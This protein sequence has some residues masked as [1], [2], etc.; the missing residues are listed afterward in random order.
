[1]TTAKKASNKKATTVKAAN[2]NVLTVQ[3]LHQA[4]MN[5]NQLYVDR[6]KAKGKAPD[7][8]KAGFHESIN[9]S[10]N[11]LKGLT[12]VHLQDIASMG[13][14]ETVLNCLSDASNIK[15][16]KR[17]VQALMFALT[18][19]G[20]YLQMSAKAWFLGYVGLVACG[21]KT[22]SGLKYCING[23]GDQFTSDQLASTEK[24]NKILK[25]FNGG[26]GKSSTDTCY[27]V[28][29]SDGGIAVALQCAKK[30]SRSG[31]PTANPDSPIIQKLDKIISQATDGYIELLVAQSGK[32]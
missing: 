2:V 20:N 32:K 26:L 1:M 8:N 31:L 21:V 14:N 28:A 12:D 13:L 29:F 9:C 15:K 11:A 3:Q 5:A 6:T 22:V 23:K 24:A 7:L 19:N 16:T 25:K 30:D 18:G 17:I 27:S 10:I 4:L